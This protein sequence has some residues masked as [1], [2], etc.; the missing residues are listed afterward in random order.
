MVGPTFASPGS[1]TLWSNFVPSGSPGPP[2]MTGTCTTEQ[3]GEHCAAAGWQCLVLQ[4]QS[5]VW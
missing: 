4:A 5:A 1:F 3:I 2:M